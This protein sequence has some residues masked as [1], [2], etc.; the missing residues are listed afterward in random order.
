M[1]EFRQGALALL[2][3][4]AVGAS[5]GCDLTVA[6][7]RVSAGDV[8]ERTYELGETPTLTIANTNGSITVETHEAA[9]IEVRA[10]RT[11]RASTDA[12]AQELLEA[13]TITEDVTGTSVSLTTRR[14][15]AFSRGQRAEVRYSVR[16]PRGAAVSLR[17]TNGR[18]EVAGVQGQVD[19]ESVNGR[20]Q[21][22]A[23]GQVR[24]AETVNGSVELAFDGVPAGGSV[25]ETVNGSVELRLPADTAADVNV[26]TVNGSID[27]DGFTQVEERQRRR[28]SY[29]GRLNGGGPTLRVETVNGSVTVRAR[30]GRPGS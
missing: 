18:L 13:T 4:G 22:T 12:G 16:V 2:L 27:V 19:V 3:T 23:L 20:V 25:V 21:G 11:V 14:P 28:R 30:R 9:T 8:W 5:A 7:A 24:R 29:E 17:T 10:E 1:H 15:A 6:G 26:R